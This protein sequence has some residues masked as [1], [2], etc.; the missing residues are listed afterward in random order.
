MVP[1]C[2][3]KYCNGVFFASVLTGKRTG[4]SGIEVECAFALVLY[5]GDEIT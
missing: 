4:V 5:M 1:Y 2:V 3:R